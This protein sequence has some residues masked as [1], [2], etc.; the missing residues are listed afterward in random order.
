MTKHSNKL[1]L[2]KMLRFILGNRPNVLW[3][4][5]IFVDHV[6][7][8]SLQMSSSSTWQIQRFSRYKLD[9][10]LLKKLI[11]SL[12]TLSSRANT[13]RLH[14]VYSSFLT[15]IKRLVLRTT[16]KGLDLSMERNSIQSLI[17]FRTQSKT[18]NLP[19][20]VAMK[21]PQLKNLGSQGSLRMV[22]HKIKTTIKS[23]INILPN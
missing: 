22:K 9:S 7:L 6:N 21:A 10:H 2:T 5:T 16:E 15:F 1:M 23:C 17:T 14:L 4:L 18:K 19:S 12:S 11:I 8:A 13:I 20:S 3:F